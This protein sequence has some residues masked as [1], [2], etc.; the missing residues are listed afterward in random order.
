LRSNYQHDG[1]RLPKVF[2]MLHHTALMET[3]DGL[4]LHTESWLPEGKPFATLILVHGYGE[5]LGRYRH[6]AEH[7]VNTGFAIYALDHRG[8]GKSEGLRAYVDRFGY[9]IADLHQFVLRVRLAHPQIKVFML[10]HSLGALI[11]TTYCQTHPDQMDGLITSGVPLNADANVSPLLVLAGNVL[12]NII[13]KVPFLAF[14][15]MDILSR[16]PQ[17]VRAFNEDPLTWKQPMRVRLGVEINHAAGRARADV[18]R[19]KLPLL[20]LHGAADQMVAPS[21][22]Q[23]LYDGAG[24]KDKTLKFYAE[25]RHEIMNEPE[26]AEVFADIEDWLMERL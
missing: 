9:F 23:T 22:S 16:D 10:G 7:F 13:P 17:V 8:H 18:S 2:T 15:D 24:S 3:A 5:H 6:V 19:L 25:L 11:A 26:K 21:G 1:I 20:V 14:G 12:T 4:K